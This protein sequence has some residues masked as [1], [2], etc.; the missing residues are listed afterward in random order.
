MVTCKNCELPFEGKY[1]PN[2][3]QKADTHRFTLG[4][5]GH[6]IFH[7]FTHADKGII[8]LIKE[9]L[10]RPGKVASEYAAGKIKKYFS[11][12]T[13]YLLISAFTLFAISKSNFY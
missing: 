3:S 9:L 5:I 4:H 6:E 7:A 2:C 11:P 12:L 8:F 1:C 13:F 10:L